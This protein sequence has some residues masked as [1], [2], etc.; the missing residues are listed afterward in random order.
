MSTN[1]SPEGLLKHAKSTEASI[2]RTRTFHHGPRVVDVDI[3]FMGQRSVHLGGDDPDAEGALEVP[4]RRLHERSF[5]LGPL[6]DLC[7]D[8]VHPVLGFSVRVLLA[9]LPRERLERVIPVKQ[10]VARSESQAP[11]ATDVESLMHLGARTFVM[12]ILNVTPDSFSNGGKFVD[13]DAAVH[14]ARSMAA[15]G[16]DI[17]DI[18]GQST[19][20]GAELVSAA[21]EAARVLPVLGALRAA[22]AASLPD[23]PL[24]RVVV[25]VDTFYSSVARAAVVA[26]AGI[27][28]DVSAGLLDPLML[29]T[30]AELQTPIVLMHMRGTPGTMAQL[31]SYGAPVPPGIVPTAAEVQAAEEVGV[32]ASVAAALR[33]RA[34]AA[35]SA[36]VFS[37]NIILDPGLGFAKSPV[38]SLALLRQ[39]SF[40]AGDWLSAYWS[41]ALPRNPAALPLTSSALPFPL[42]YG[43]SRK[44]FIAAACTAGTLEVGGGPR[45]AAERDWGTAAAVTA[46][47][48]LGADFVRVHSPECMRDVVAVADAIY[49][50]FHSSPR[51]GAK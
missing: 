43:P 28:N 19:R 33:E 16:A 51:S 7:P 21:A 10:L 4:H 23:D 24:R 45:P 5:V 34:A 37:W 14:Q 47:I 30:A 44:G 12:G 36:G 39:P 25:S 46:S 49:R 35:L 20:P 50:G 27:I 18:G 8:L 32:V 48:C 29:G 41:S 17:I 6:M 3:L 38:H 1:L 13:V 9:R 42:L 40:G 2:G 31:A 26:G 22:T 15:A 11:D